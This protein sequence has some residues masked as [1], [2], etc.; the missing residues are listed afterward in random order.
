MAFLVP[1]PRARKVQKRA[2][3][4]LKPSQADRKVETDD[5]FVS[6]VPN[7][8]IEYFFLLLPLIAISSP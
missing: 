7:F 8:R 5:P 3:T 6:T 1:W 4:L 2:E